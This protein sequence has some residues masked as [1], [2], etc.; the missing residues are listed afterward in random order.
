MPHADIVLLVFVSY[1]F[2]EKN[3]GGIFRNTFI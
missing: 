1:E 2:T 3:G